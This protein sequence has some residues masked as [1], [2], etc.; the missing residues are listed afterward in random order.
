MRGTEIPVPSATRG[1][2][3]GRRLASQHVGGSGALAGNC[4]VWG[5]GRVANTGV[6]PVTP[7]GLPVGL[8]RLLGSRGLFA[9]KAI[10]KEVCPCSSR[11][12]SHAPH[13]KS[14]VFEHRVYP[15]ESA[16]RLKC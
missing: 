8:V 14:S 10:A 1:I 7:G 6:E 12:Q 3:A 15:P 9:L 4:L 5:Y 2:T 11:R 13:R 16:Q